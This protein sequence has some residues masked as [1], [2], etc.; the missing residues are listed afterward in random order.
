MQSRITRKPQWRF[1]AYAD[2]LAYADAGNTVP[3]VYQ[4]FANGFDVVSGDIFQAYV[5]G[6]KDQATVLSELDEAYKTFI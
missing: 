3:W 4:Q 2:Y 6:A 5:F 1:Q